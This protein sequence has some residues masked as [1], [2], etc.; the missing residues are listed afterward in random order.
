ME[1][2]R[3]EVMKGEGGGEGGEELTAKKFQLANSLG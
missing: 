2:V 3:G 1:V